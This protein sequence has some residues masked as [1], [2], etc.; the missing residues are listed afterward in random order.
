MNH[1]LLKHYAAAFFSIGKEKN[2]IQTF[3]KDLSFFSDVFRKEPE[4]VKF[5]SS[6]MVT[7]DEKDKLL[8]EAIK[9]YVDIA[10]YGFLQV[11]IKKKVISYFPEIKE[12]F[13]H[14]FHEDQGILEGRVYTPFELS[15]ETLS[16]LSD[17]FSKKYQK[18]VVFK[19][20]ID[21]KVIG[22]MKVYVNDTLYDYSL[23]SKL[24]QIRQR[25]VVQ[26]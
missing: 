2:R 7:K 20:L 21:K 10:S 19:V 22:G 25:L 4:T 24:N 5:L 13:D 1:S 6:P 12:N 18:K 15:E 9:P 16:K 11:I 8:E 3:Q 17:V 14:L 26:D 23:D